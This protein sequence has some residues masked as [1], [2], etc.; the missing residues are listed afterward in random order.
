M[1]SGVFGP[2]RIGLSTLPLLAKLW[3]SLAA[4][5]CLMVLWH[6]VCKAFHI[7]E[8]ILPVALAVAGGF[9]EYRAIL[10]PNCVFSLMAM[11]SGLTIGSISGIALGILAGENELVRRALSPVLVSIQSVPKLALAPVLLL[12][13]G[14]GLLP[15]VILV[16]V[17]AVFPMLIGTISGF[18]A[19]DPSHLDLM[20]SL[21]AN[22]TAILRKVRIPAAAPSMFAGLKV[23]IPGAIVAAI[24]AEWVGSSSGLGYVMLLANSQL[25]TVLLFDALLLL[26][27]F[28]IALIGIVTWF[29]AVLLSWRPPLAEPNK[30]RLGG[31]HL[32]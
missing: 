3:H 30:R 4:V 21:H 22:R 8:Y 23:A 12:W 6:I 18:D 1:Q 16:S 17:S 11:V 20:R 7:P 32:A 19:V 10:V 13:F 31:P 27:G 26:S 9:R 2:R 28:G 5:L 15:K 14:Y 25:N 24:V 29:E